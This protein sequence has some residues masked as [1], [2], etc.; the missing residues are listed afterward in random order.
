MFDDISSFL[1]LSFERLFFVWG[2]KN[3]DKK[4]RKEKKRGKA[5]LLCVN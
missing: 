4:K 1:F 5:R 2:K 3:D